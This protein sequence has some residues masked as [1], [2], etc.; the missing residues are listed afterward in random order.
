MKAQRLLITQLAGV[1]YSGS[2]GSTANCV[3]AIARL[4]YSGELIKNACLIT[5]SNFH[6]FIL[7]SQFDDVFVIKNGFASGYSGEGPKALSTAIELLERHSIDIE[8]HEV[9]EKFMDR[10]EQSCL[11]QSDIKNIKSAHPI[12]PRRIV[13]YR[14]FSNDD[15][16]R[17]A[18]YLAHCLPTGVPFGLIDNRIMDLA[19]AFHEDEDR[20]IVTAYRRLENIVRDRTNISESGSKLFSKAFLSEDSPLTWKVEDSNEAIGRGTMFTAVF[21]A[22]RNARMHREQRQSRNE[23][24]RE[25]LLVNE[26]FLLESKAIANRNVGLTDV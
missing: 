2:A 26:L 11:L 18:A 10:L 21:R 3:R 19:V 24:L 7:F 15:V 8:E 23:S 20:A 25:L 4:L 5:W 9:N 22:F 6:A 14:F 1:E 13:D 16:T 12:R 17:S